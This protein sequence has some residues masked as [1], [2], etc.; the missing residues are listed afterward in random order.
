MFVARPAKVVI[1]DLRQPGRR[2][3][4]GLEKV[5]AAGLL[6]AAHQTEE[7]LPGVEDDAFAAVARI[8]EGT[9]GFCTPRSQSRI[10]MA[11]SP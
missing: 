8:G 4:G 11:R 1:R 2:A 3:A 7:D 5:G 6:V 10:R 9:V